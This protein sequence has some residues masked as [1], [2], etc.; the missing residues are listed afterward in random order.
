MIN[1]IVLNP[2]IYESKRKHTRHFYVYYDMFDITW[3]KNEKYFGTNY[4]N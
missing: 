2:Q 3:I 4:I 1:A